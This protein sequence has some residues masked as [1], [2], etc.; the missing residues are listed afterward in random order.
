M[1]IRLKEGKQTV[2][3]KQYPLKKK[4][5]EGISPTIENFLQ[6][7]LLKECQSQF[8]TPILPVKKPDRSYR[9]VQDLRA[10]N[11]I[12]E[13][14]YPVVAN[15]Y[16][17]LTCLTPELTWFTVLD[18]K[19]AFFCLPLHEASQKIF[20]FEWK[21]PRTGH[22]VHLTWSV[23]PQR[24][25]NSPTIFGEQ[26]ARCL[27]SWETPSGEGQL[28]QYV[29]DLLIATKT[30]ETC[31]EWMKFL[32]YQAIMVEQDDVEIVVTNVVNP[33]SFLSGSPGEPVIHDCLEI[34]KATYSSR[35][36][37]KDTPLEDTETWFT[38]G[39]SYVI[40]GKRH[41]GL[42]RMRAQISRVTAKTPDPEVENPECCGEWEDMGQTL[43]KFSDPMVCNFPPE[44]VQ[45][46]SEVAKYLKEKYN[47]ISN[48]NKLLAI[49]WAL[50]YAYR[51]L[52]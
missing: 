16:I 7:G 44:Q 21:N 39:S 1:Q 25:K 12:T 34:I 5:R 22:K 36:D 41:A 6:I 30:Q 14:L 38:D 37:L 47:E 11:K 13:D 33:A 4:D 28:L 40:S 32:K 29:D 23:L 48:E 19:D 51:T 49:R 43:K 27:E 10:I 17:L 2:R 26:L 3:I 24:F 45:K 8:N 15:P 52:Q 42:S 50:A 31:V 9:I 20:A 46:P 18:L 35:P